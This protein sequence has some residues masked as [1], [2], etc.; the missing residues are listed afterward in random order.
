MDKMENNLDYNIFG[1]TKTSEEVAE[2]ILIPITWD[3]TVS[4]E[5]GTYLGP[6]NIY[7]MAEQVDFGYFENTWGKSFTKNG[8]VFMLDSLPEIPELAEENE[9]WRALVDHYMTWSYDNPDKPLLPKFQKFL[10]DLNNRCREIN[11]EVE[12][13]V[14]SYLEKGKLVGLIGG[15]H[16]VIFGAMKAHLKF[17]KEPFALIHFDAH[18]DAREAYLKFEYSHASIIYNILS[19]NT[20]KLGGY[21]QLGARDYDK[22]E[23]DFIETHTKLIPKHIYSHPEYSDLFDLGDFTTKLEFVINDF[24]LKGINNIYVTF[25][26]DVL[27][28]SLCPTTG[29][30]V[31]GGLSFGK[32]QFVLNQL[33]LNFKIIGFDLVEVGSEEE[34]DGNVGA[35]ILQM[36]SE[37]T[38]L[39]N[40]KDND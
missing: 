12:K 30:P 33:S 39:S 13:T 15:D 1:V 26:I 40:K 37:Y 17:Q 2:L 18:F 11:L 23:L 38:L 7:E 28:P 20:G 16:S 4:G 10:F 14:L 22:A 34:W 21:F 6:D 27:D 32:V 9:R 8:K 24:K 5:S 3:V 19:S 25:D 36:L 35:R 29:T 31:P